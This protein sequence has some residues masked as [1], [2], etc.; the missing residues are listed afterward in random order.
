MYRVSLAALALLLA[1]SSSSGRTGAG[2]KKESG[3][4]AKVR[5]ELRELHRALREAVTRHDRAALES[6]Y[7]DEFFY[8]H[9]TGN[10]ETRAEWIA[11]SLTVE[12]AAAGPPPALEE[13]ALH[14]Y[15]DVAVATRRNP[16]VV[17]G[18]LNPR[19]LWNTTIYVRRGGRWRIAQMQGTPIPQP[20]ESAAVDPKILDAYVGRYEYA[21][22]DYADI[23]REGD[24]LFSRRA[25]RAKVALVAE[26]EARFFVKGTESRLT[27]FKDEEGRVTHFTI[28]R[29]ERPEETARKIK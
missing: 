5:E 12:S 26:T 15:G 11:R 7:A 20:R 18:R 1:C 8:V 10:A 21:P 17:N 4:V 3:A 23:T 25:G 9:S 13:F 29:G 28:R 2:Q 14:V 16:A 19:A 24:A 27:F 22:G 6:F